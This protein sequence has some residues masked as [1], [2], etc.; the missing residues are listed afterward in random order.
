M[1]SA[2]P[3]GKHTFHGRETRIPRRET[4]N[5]L[6][7]LVSLKKIKLTFNLLMHSVF[8]ITPPVRVLKREK[9]NQKSKSHDIAILPSATIRLSE[10]KRKST[11]THIYK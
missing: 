8:A 1:E 4:Q 7:S 3:D 6:S 2:F 10:R 11:S 5:D 9:E